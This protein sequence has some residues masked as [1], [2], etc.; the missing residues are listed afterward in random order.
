[1]VRSAICRRATRPASTLPSRPQA[2]DRPW[3]RARASRYSRSNRKTLCPSM[4][5]GS[6]SRI[7]RVHSARSAGSSS[8]SPRTTWRKPVESASATATMRSPGRAALGNSWPSVVTTSMSRASRR[9]S[10]NPR[11]PNEVRPVRSRYW[12]TGSARKRYG[13]AGEPADCPLRSRQSS[14]APRASD[15]EPN[16]AIQRSSPGPSSVSTE[17][18]PGASAT[19][20]L[21][22]ARRNGENGACSVATASPSRR[23]SVSARPPRARPNAR[24]PGAGSR[25]KR[26]GA[27]GRVSPRLGEGFLHGRAVGGEVG[28]P[29]ERA[30]G[31]DDDDRR[32]RGD[33][34]LGGGRLEVGEDGLAPDA[35]REVCREAPHVGAG[36][37]DD[38]TDH[39][40]VADVAALGEVGLVEPEVHAL[41]QRLILLLDALRRLERGEAPA[42]ELAVRPRGEAD[43]VARRHRSAAP[44]A[45]LAIR[46]REQDAARGRRA[47]RERA[48]LD[49]KRVA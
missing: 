19:S 2:S 42:R 18:S 6:R 12:W 28:Q 15:Q 35:G 16:R 25:P 1:M 11:P 33:A 10:S 17:T 49:A 43:P 14:R 39:S 4:T 24:R 26:S 22:A 27:R 47:Q 31:L 32:D 21:S 8:R 36:G 3:S 41:E 13:A 44:P 7:S 38:V 45:L 29:H 30:A 34:V 9:R 48:R 46:A 37:G 20:V 5:S 40:G 23:H